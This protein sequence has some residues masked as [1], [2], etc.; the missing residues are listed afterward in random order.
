[1]AKQDAFK[2][3]LSCTEPIMHKLWNVRVSVQLIEKEMIVF[4]VVQ[5][6]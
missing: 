1:M 3:L 4:T 2:T 6:K 5:L